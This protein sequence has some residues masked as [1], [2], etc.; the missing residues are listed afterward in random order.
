M[1]GLVFASR[2]LEQRTFLVLD[3]GDLAGGPHA[4]VGVE[5]NLTSGGVLDRLEKGVY[6]DGIRFFRFAVGKLRGV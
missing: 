1:V 4:G 5:D 6:R 3:I 2:S